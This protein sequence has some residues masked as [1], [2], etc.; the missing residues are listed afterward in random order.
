MTVI[1]SPLIPCLPG[2]IPNP[3]GDSMI[4]WI[5]S[6]KNTCPGRTAYLT[7]GIPSGKFH[8]LIGYSID[9]WTFVKSGPLITEIPGPHIIHQNKQHIGTLGC[10]PIEKECIRKDKEYKFI[11]S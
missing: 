2:S 10:K 4:G 3:G 8:S 6:G 7:G 9:V 11:H 5:F 1:S